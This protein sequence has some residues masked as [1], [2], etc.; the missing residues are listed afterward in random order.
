MSSSPIPVPIGIAMDSA[1][2]VTA[3]MAL[4]K[5]LNNHYAIVRTRPLLQLR[6]RLNSCPSIMPLRCSA[7]SSGGGGDDS[8]IILHV[9]GMMCEGC[10]ANVKRILE[11]RPQVSSATVNLT[12]EIAIVSPVSEEKTA[13]N[14]QNRLGEALAQ[15]LTSCGFSS[16]LRGQEDSD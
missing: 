10:A 11:S 16:S 7:A 14:W 3:T 1:F 9:G 12:S 4:F 13:P 8:I 6:R 5:P 2:S 15:H